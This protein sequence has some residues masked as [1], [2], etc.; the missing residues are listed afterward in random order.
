MVFFQDNVVTR[1]KRCIC[2]E[3]PPMPLPQFDCG[4]YSQLQQQSQLL[5]SPPS[6]ISSYPQVAENGQTVMSY[7][8]QQQQTVYQNG[9]QTVPTG[10]QIPSANGLPVAYNSFSR[11]QAFENSQIPYNGMPVTENSQNFPDQ[12]QQMGSTNMN[13]N[14]GVPSSQNYGPVAGTYPNVMQSIPTQNTQDNYNVVVKEQNLQNVQMNGATN[15]INNQGVPQHFSSY[16]SLNNNMGQSQTTNFGQ[17]QQLQYGQSQINYGQDQTQMSFGEDSQSTFGQQLPIS[18]SPQPEQ[19]IGSQSLGYGHQA[20]ARSLQPQDCN[21]AC[22]N[23]CM[24]ECMKTGP[25]ENCRSMCEQSCD[26]SCHRR[27]GE[28]RVITQPAIQYAGRCTE[29]CENN[30]FKTCASDKCRV[31]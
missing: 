24:Q 8:Q 18:N 22:L 30:C 16:V 10:Q 7:N 2:N 3:P 21:N 4:C 1:G 25:A 14:V 6:S 28:F 12:M 15:R 5:G 9:I 23:V 27:Q 13:L 17:S 31:I 11:S 29:V 20:A 19:Q 26:L